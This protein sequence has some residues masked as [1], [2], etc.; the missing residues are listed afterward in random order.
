[1]V[2]STSKLTNS[3]PLQNQ[4]GTRATQP[5]SCRNW[6]VINICRIVIDIFHFRKFAPRKGCT[7]RREAL[8]GV[9]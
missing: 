1:M 8:K 6:V 9:G 2:D 7:D 4:S 3:T 5:L